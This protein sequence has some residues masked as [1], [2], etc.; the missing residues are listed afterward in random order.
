MMPHLLANSKMELFGL[1]A[2][3]VIALRDCGVETS[4]SEFYKHL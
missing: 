2:S 3:L 4:D 1:G